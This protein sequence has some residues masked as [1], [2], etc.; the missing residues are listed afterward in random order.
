MKKLFYSILFLAVISS[1]FQSCSS[2]DDNGGSSLNLNDEV[3]IDGTIYSLDGGGYLESYGIN[4]DGSYDWDVTLLSTSGI[5]VYFDLNTN[6]EDGLVEGTYT[7]SETRTEFSYVYTEFYGESIDYSASEGTI[8]VTIDGD[9][10]GFVFSLTAED[11][12]EIEGEW[13]GELTQ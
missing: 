10:V 11:G 8:V 9:T 2:D 6:S 12:S 3:S 5:S 7:Y 1:T 13:S 4:S